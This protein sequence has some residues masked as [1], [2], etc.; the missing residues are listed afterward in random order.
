QDIDIT[1]VNRHP[2][3]LFTPLLL[4]V[5]SGNI[6]P[7]RVTEDLQ[8]TFGRYLDH[9][10]VAEVEQINLE[11]KVVI[12]SNGELE[13]DYLVIALGSTANYY[14]IPG[15]QE[16]TFP[17]K[18]LEDATVIKSKLK[19]IFSTETRPVISVVGAGAKGVDLAAEIYEVAR[20]FRKQHVTTINLIEKTHTILPLHSTYFQ[21]HAAKVLQKKQI[22]S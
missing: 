6:P 18:E 14:N 4:E 16:N 22:N 12:T 10:V 1:V 17:L 11:D 9:L 15:A 21:R 13:Y 3:F 19:E 8:G 2:Y 20:Y 5:A 7:E